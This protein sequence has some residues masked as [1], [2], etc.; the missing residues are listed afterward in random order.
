M[1]YFCFYI[2]LLWCSSIMSQVRLTGNVRDED[3]LPLPYVSM[4]LMQDSIEIQGTSTDSLGNFSFSK[5]PGGKYLLDFFYLGQNRLQETIFLKK[6][7]NICRSIKDASYNLNEIVIK[8]NKPTLKRKADRLVFNVNNSP[9]AKNTS[10]VELLKYSPMVRTKDD[11]INIIGKNKT[12]VLINGKLSYLNVSDLMNYLK[13]IQAS[14]IIEIEVITTPPAKYDAEGNTGYINVVLKKNKDE[15]WNGN[16]NLSYIQRSYAG[17]NN[18]LSLNYHSPKV[19]IYNNIS[20]RN[21]KGKIN[22]NYR[23][24]QQDALQASNTDRIDK[25]TSFNVNSTVEYQ[26][27]SKSQIGATYN[28]GRNTEKIN[29]YNVFDYYSSESLDSTL[30]TISRHSGNSL[31]HTVN[32]FYEY[33]IDSLGKKISL[34][35]NFMHYTPDKAIDF[36]TQNNVTDNISIVHEPNSLSDRI[37]TGQTDIELPFNMLTIEMGGKYSDIFNKSKISYLNKDGNNYIEDP[38]RSNGFSY[39][40][41]NAAGYLSLSKRISKDLSIQAGLRYEHTTVKGIS[42]DKNAEKIKYNYGK[43]FPTFYIMY[44]LD[45]KQNLSANYSRR[46]NRP[47][48]RAINPFKWYTNPNVVDC[49]NP[50]LRPSFNDNLETNYTYNNNLSI[51]VYYQINNDA[52]DQITHVMSDNSL[53]STYENIYNNKR[54]GINT[55]YTIYWSKWINTY[56]EMSYDYS[57]SSIKNELFDPQNGGSFDYRINNLINLDK[58]KK[59]QLSIGYSQTT[60]QKKGDSYTHSYANLNMTFTYSIHDLIFKVYA[61]DILKQDILKR[62]KFGNSNSQF[63]H[64]YYDSKYFNVSFVYKIG[65]SKKKKK[66]ILFHEQNRI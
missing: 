53:F 25:Y 13:S 40:E 60:S 49:G 30:V 35:G 23:I 16:A 41:K 7:T 27:T 56:L 24:S 28:F 57:K 50:L 14:E 4:R 31:S 58:K 9:F 51:M 44:K 6:D 15:G 19:D 64:N 18:Y 47:F 8:A 2:F 59:Y 29:S 21:N 65:K 66:T 48:F 1:K 33:K 46:I 63:Y 12:G 3:N 17:T 22:E 54:L 52:Y 42:S 55:N 43:W 34:I 39:Y 45:D 61:N 26:I 5:I 20:Y 11:Q 10:V 62:E 38:H 37:M 36:T 32:A